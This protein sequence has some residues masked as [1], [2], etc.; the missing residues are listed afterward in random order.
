MKTK[1]NSKLFEKQVDIKICESVMGGNFA[2]S[3]GTESG[4]TYN[5]ADV[6]TH[7]LDDNCNV[8]YES[9]SFPDLE[10]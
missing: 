5:G 2:T 6:Y 1:F 8:S 10:K 9:I 4:P 3:G 7:W